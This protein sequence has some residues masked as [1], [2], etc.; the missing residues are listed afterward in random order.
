VSKKTALYKQHIAA[1]G[2]MVQFAGW[3]MPIHYGSQ[4]NEHHYV[5]QE[6]G[7]FDVSHMTIVEVQGRD[8]KAY[9]RPLLANDIAKLTEPGEALYTCMLNEQGGIV[10]DL[11]VYFIAED[12]YRL[13]VNA[14]TREKDLAWLNRHIQ[15][16]QVTVKTRDDLA[17][18]AI[19]GPQARQKVNPLLPDA[20]LNSITSLNG[21][22]FV[23]FDHWLVA[24]TGY[25]G[26]DGY[27]IM[28]PTEQAGKFW[29][30]IVKAGIKP[31]GLGARDTLRLEA[32]LNLYG[33][34]MDESTT[35][36]E[37]NLAWTI[38]WQ[39]PERDF[40]GRTALILQQQNG[41]KHK[42]VGLVLT[43]RGV[44]RSHQQIVLADS[45]VGETT[46]GTFSP[47]LNKGIALARMPVNMSDTCQI[48][49]RG[50][51]VTA[52]VVKPPFVRQGLPSQAINLILKINIERENL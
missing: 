41:V 44:L 7:V 32:G 25:T 3:E 19:Q 13:V 10:D 38:A 48:D 17:I 22:Q 40:I 39:P 34:D 51:L 18:L 37:S 23:M 15:A 28:L 16:Y 36:L 52:H 26:E 47:T 29:Q 11:I 50:K 31:C 9:L 24:R 4:L 20:F 2:K 46:S 6:A 30:A 43:E 5:R 1:G 45:P 33:S 49:M 12:Y 35:P 21:F 14:S 27:E 42:L 8:S